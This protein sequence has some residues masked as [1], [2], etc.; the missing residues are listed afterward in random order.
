[1]AIARF[2][3]MLGTMLRNGVPM[4]GALATSRAAAGNVVLEE[5][6]A[7]AGEQVG[8]GAQLAPSLA[9]SGLFSADVI[10]ML[11]VGEE[12]GNVDRVLILIAD[13]VESRIERLLTNLI[14]LVEPL[15]IAII[16]AVVLV[17]AISLILPLTQLSNVG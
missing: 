7:E 5:A 8:A 3:R 15:L 4:L 9:K 2:C 11:T 16:A 14:R 12:A 17:V 13:T 10:E 6:I 1:V